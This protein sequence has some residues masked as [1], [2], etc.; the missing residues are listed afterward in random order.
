MKLAAVFAALLVLP[1]LA[2][3]S[4]SY[5]TRIGQVQTAYLED[6]PVGMVNALDISDR[7]RE[8]VDAARSSGAIVGPDGRVFAPAPVNKGP[9]AEFETWV[10]QK[11]RDYAESVVTGTTGVERDGAKMTIHRFARDNFRNIYVTYTVIVEAIPETRTFRVSFSE[12]TIPVPVPQILRQGETIALNLS[13]DARTGRRM[14][15]YIRV[16]TALFGKRRKP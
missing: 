4:A 7:F 6:L 14:V 13:V 1:A 8:I 9:R 11:S 3:S 16:G 10:E 12:S 5:G 15:D 2:Q